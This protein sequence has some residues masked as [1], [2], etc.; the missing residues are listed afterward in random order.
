L[1]LVLSVETGDLRVLIEAVVT[2][3]SILGG[4]MAYRSG[5]AAAKAMS[6]DQ[7]PQILA[8]RINEG[9]GKGFSAGLPAA[10]FCLI[11]LLWT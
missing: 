3:V 10:T 6:Q 2:A 11:V 4:V 7:T 8:Q 5:L 1:G 9:L